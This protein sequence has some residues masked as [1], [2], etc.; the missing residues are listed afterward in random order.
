MRA[1]R[2]LL[3]LLVA[4]ALA[5]A[6]CSSTEATDAS[7]GAGAPAPAAT[8]AGK[9]DIERP[10]PPE[11]EPVAG[12][13]GDYTMTSF[14]GTEIRLHWYPLDREAPTI[15]MGPGW[16]QPGATKDSGTGLFG[17]SP[18]SVLQ[19]QDYHVLTWDPRGFG[20]STGTITVDS[21]TAEGKDVQRIVDW[22]ATRPGVQLDR[23]GDPRFGMV[24]GS[25]GGGIQLI[26]AAIDC[27]VDA[28][29]PTIA[30]HSLSTSLYKAGTVKL[31]WSQ[32]LYTAAA[33]RNLDPHITS[34]YESG[35][36]RGVVAPEDRRWF[37][38]RGPD[39]LVRRITAPTLFIQGTVDTLFTLD[40]AVTNYG[41]LRDEKVP[42]SMLWYCGG[43]GVCLADPGDEARVAEATNVWLR[44]YLRG[45]TATDTGPR[46]EV[47]D[48][49]G[50]RYTATDW[51]IAT[52]MR[53]RAEGSGS[54]E[55]VENGGAGPA[56]PKTGS[57]NP[58]GSAA[59]GI[60]PARAENAVNVEIR[61]TSAGTSVGA[62]RL[63]IVYSGTTPPGDRPTRVFAQL[64]DD[65]TGLVLGNQITPI[66]VVLDGATHR[67]RIPLEMIGHT[68]AEGQSVTLQIV[69]NTV[70]YAPPRFGG[71][72]EFTKIAI[73]LPIA[74]GLTPVD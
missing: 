73:E 9:C 38:S 67:L 29:V 41:I 65:E 47:L 34:A 69:G 23:P 30:W 50:D 8:P 31:G 19:E 36:D 35:R 57:T 40:E 62:P 71:A 37:R 74:K 28:I 5:G 6:A 18:I 13:E 22:V 12:V 59:A 7:S 51:P 44:R 26:T 17:D 3:L 64:V 10:A 55:L 25:Y 66:P 58:I 54:L 24:G 46:V 42:T 32:L 15:L 70:A 1:L 39:A 68:F 33:G 43:H 60:T 14:D 16:S 20:E 11:V 49:R 21:A 45:D 27:R 63:T 52:A 61:A 2:A 72:I 4:I 53:L 48:Q 56:T